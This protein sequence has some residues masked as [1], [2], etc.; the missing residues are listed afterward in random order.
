MK[1]KRQAIPLI[2]LIYTVCYI[3]RI[4]DYFLIRTDQ[5]II[6][7]AFL[8]KLFGILVIF[9]IL[10]RRNYRLEDIGIKKQ[11]VFKY[12]IYGLLFGLSMFT[13]GYFVEVLILKMQGNF[14]AIKFYVSAYAVDENI[15][16][17]TGF[18]FILICILGNVINV[19]MEEG[20]FRGLF[21]KL[22]E[23]TSYIK[24]SL[25]CSILFG[26]WHIIGPIRNF[27]DGKSSLQGMI[28]NI[29]MLLISSSL[30]AF[31]FAMLAKLEGTL[32]MGMA[33]HFVNNA[34]VNLLHV[35]SKSGADEM[36][37]LRITV[38]QCISFVLVLYVFLRKRKPKEC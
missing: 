29:I 28:A 20:L 33:D 37:F 27:I 13:I 31:K 5:T 10:S 24:V 7:E 26:F 35:V 1:Q 22:M 23:Q 21:P 36:M 18:I 34:I 11:G 8:H 25:F 17:K 32:Y 4:V 2:F 6:G 16:T 15:V 14:Q 38:A 19:M 30:I 12:T 3:A 9:V